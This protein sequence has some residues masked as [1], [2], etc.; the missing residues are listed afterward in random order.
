MERRLGV[1]IPAYNAAARV[2]STVRAALGI[3]LPGWET[4]VLVV[5]DGSRDGTAV[6]ATAAGAAV[7]RLPRNG[8]KGRAVAAG[9]AALPADA[10]LFLD[11]D[12]GETAAEGCVLAEPV[13]AGR[14]D[15]AVAVMPRRGAG[16]GLAV[17]LARAGTLALAG[18][19]LEAPLSGQRCLNRRAWEA[20]R[21]DSGFGLEAGM[22]VD[23]LRAGLRL[24]EVPTAMG[25]AAT[26]WNPAGVWHRGR[27][28]LAVA[29]ALAG[30]WR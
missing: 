24:V 30:R 8:G 4:G 1:V 16:L 15:V 6:R 9:V 28:F 14:A 17:G 11:A 27:Q 25:H 2:E 10:W 3:V 7:L 5:D 22:N 26:G 23:V 18:R 12:L 13:A 29:G 19:W 20:C 21:P